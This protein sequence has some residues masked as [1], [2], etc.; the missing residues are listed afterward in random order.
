VDIDGTTGVNGTTLSCG[1][2][3]NNSVAHRKAWFELVGKFFLQMRMEGVVHCNH[4]QM[5]VRGSKKRIDG[6]F[7]FNTFFRASTLENNE[8]RLYPENIM[9]LPARLNCS[10]Q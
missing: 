7:L 8:Y 9:Y 10:N 4:P 1:T 6:A 5:T 3:K 2:Q